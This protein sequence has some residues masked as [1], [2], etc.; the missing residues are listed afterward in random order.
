[1]QAF[2]TAGLPPSSGSTILPTIGWTMNSSDALTN[3]VTANS[4]GTG[5]LP[6]AGATGRDGAGPTSGCIKPRARRIVPGIRRQA[7]VVGWDEAL[8][9]PTVLP[10]LGSPVGLRGLVP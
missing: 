3:S 9:S 5:Q 8:R 4:S 10:H 6:G 2:Q 7:S 1:M